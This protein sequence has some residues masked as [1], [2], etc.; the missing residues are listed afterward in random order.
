[1]RGEETAE[2]RFHD[3]SFMYKSRSEGRERP[4]FH[5]YKALLEHESRK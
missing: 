5:K 2:F 1:M 3:L 4:S